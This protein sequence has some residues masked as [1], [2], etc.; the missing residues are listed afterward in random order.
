M[1]FRPEIQGLRTVAA[2]LVAVY[3]VWFDRVSGGVDIFF[4]VSGFLI[5]G[6]LVR[7]AERGGIR[8]GAHLRRIGRRIVPA[9]YLVLAATALATL[10][11]LSRVYWASTF[12]E[13]TAAAVYLANVAFAASAV[14]YLAH[15]EFQSPVLHFW[16]LSIQGQFYV[17]WP[18]LIGLLAWTARR[19]RAP[20]RATLLVGLGAV[21]AA[22]LAYGMVLTVTQQQVAYFSMPA[23]M[24]EFALGGIVA[25]TIH[26]VSLRPRAA[27]VLAGVALIVILATGAVLDVARLFPGFAALLP[28]A[29]AAAILYAGASGAR[30]GALGL[31]SSRPMVAFGDVSYAFFLWHWPLLVFS[32]YALDIDRLT[33]AQGAAL[34]VVSLAL[35]VATT[36]W[37]EQPVRRRGE[38]RANTAPA[39]RSPLALLAVVPL[40]LAAVTLALSAASSVNEVAPRLGPD[41][42]G[43]AALDSNP[44]GDVEDLVDA[45]VDIV[46]APVEAADSNPAPYADGCHQDQ[47]SDEAATCAYGAVGA[48]TRIA[49]VG[50]SHATHWQPALAALGVEHGWEIVNI[51]K[52]ACRFGLDVERGDSCEAWNRNVV[53]LLTSQPFDAVVT[54]ATVGSA[55]TRDGEDALPAAYVRMWERLDEAGLPVIAVRDNPWWPRDVPE[56][57][58]E[59]GPT[60]PECRVARDEVL[61]ASPPWETAEFDIP[62]NVSVVDLTD[63]LCTADA[64][65]AVVG[66]VLVYR[67]PHHLTVPYAESLAPMLDRELR[68]LRPE[69]YDR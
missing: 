10:V 57:V 2:L 63:Y 19:V 34:L 7:Q 42:P 20:L 24:W 18:A 3:H 64:C 50:G 44:P 45:D 27:S 37:V 30:G 38:Q 49:L 43:A 9:A 47:E 35:A 22:S 26:R 15:D 55:E 6:S 29:S 46:P 21:F 12:E 62:G 61:A 39:W 69:L 68:A 14:D 67:D 28:T 54:T 59:H 16:A 41:Y 25:L 33:P 52:S 4:V 32:L 11:V 53:E 17:L 56:C 5:T 60:S 23:R 1:V 36:R 31:L 13:I 65:P 66:N 48:D 58:E 8:V 40:A 51:T